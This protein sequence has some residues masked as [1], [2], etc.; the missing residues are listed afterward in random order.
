MP[1]YQTCINNLLLEEGL[2]TKDHAGWT[3]Y[4]ITLRSL[5]VDIDRD[6]DVDSDDIKALTKADAIEFYKKN[7]WLQNGYDKI[8]PTEVASKVLSLSVNMGP[9]QA[10]LLVQRA[11]KSLKITVKE[12]GILDTPT[13]NAIN[14]AASYTL[15]PALKSEA[16]G[17]YRMLVSKKPTYKKYLKGWLKRA[18]A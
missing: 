17:F 18:Y 16:A 7:F 9:R 10:H 3:K 11:L 14:T 2:L 15:L 13:L 5:D 6:G 4:G 8:I 12:S 1:N